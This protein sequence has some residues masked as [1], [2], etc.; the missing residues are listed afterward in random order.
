VL[1]VDGALAMIDP[2]L[3]DPLIGMS[4][5][6]PVAEHTFRIENADGFGTHGEL[7]VFELD[8]AG[9]VRRVKVGDNYSE[10]VE[11]W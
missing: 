3:P 1:V 6:H 11:R 10:P 5:L 7:V 2:S 4:R 9:R 8:A